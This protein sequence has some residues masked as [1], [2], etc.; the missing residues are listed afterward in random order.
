[1][2]AG[3]QVMAIKKKSRRTKAFSVG[4]PTKALKGWQEIAHFLGQP[5]SVAQRWA[6]TGMPVNRSGRYVTAVPEELNSWL[7]REAGGEPVHVAT[8]V[9]DLSAE[10]KRGLS[11]VRQKK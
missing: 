11:F 7:G 3:V 4:N 8:E 6:K 9:G 10:L 2:L 5:V 1:L